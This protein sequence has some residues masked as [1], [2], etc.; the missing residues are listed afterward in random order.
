[1]ILLG[2]GCTSVFHSFNLLLSVLQPLYAGALPVVFNATVL[3]ALGVSG[4]FSS[5]PQFFAEDEGGQLLHI[6]FEYSQVSSL[7]DDSLD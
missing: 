6:S 7:V 4:T 3:N 5:P 1:M 2:N